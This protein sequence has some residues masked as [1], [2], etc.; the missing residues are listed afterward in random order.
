MV[1]EVIETAFLALPETHL[2]VLTTGSVQ[3]RID[4]MRELPRVVI[5]A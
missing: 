3:S 1:A 2:V 4:A 5:D